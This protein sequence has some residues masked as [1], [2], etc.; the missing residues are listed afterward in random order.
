MEMALLR[1]SICFSWWMMMKLFF[2][3][4]MMETTTVEAAFSTIQPSRIT[5]VYRL[6]ADV[7]LGD[8]R[9]ASTPWFRERTLRLYL[10]AG[11]EEDQGD[12]NPPQGSSKNK[13]KKKPSNK[14]QSNADSQRKKDEL[15]KAVGAQFKERYNRQKPD[16]EQ[17]QQQQPE[18]ERD[19]SN[20]ILD[21][22]NPFKAGQT[23]RRTIDTAFSSMTAVGGSQQ[24]SKKSPY[25]LDDDDMMI[26]TTDGIDYVPE[27]LVVGATTDL[28]R[29]VVQQLLRSGQFRVRVLVRDLYT[30]TLNALGT[31]VT[32]CQGD[33]NDP[34]SLEYAVTDVDKLI[35]VADAPRPD[36]T[37]FRNKFHEFTRENL[38]TTSEQTTTTTTTTTHTKG[39][40]RNEPV[41]LPETPK[42]QSDW[43]WETLESVLEV[44]ARLAEQIDLVGMQNLIR[45]YQDV[46]HADYGTS[47]AAKR[48]LFKFQSR[49][50]DFY[51]FSLDEGD[52]MVGMAKNGNADESK[53]PDAGKTAFDS[54]NGRDEYDDVYDDYDEYEDDVYG[55]D[56]ET[57]YSRSMIEKRSDAVVKTQSQWIRNQFGHGVFVGRIPKTTSVISGEA[58]IISSRLRSREDP[59]NGIDLGP[60]FAGFVCRVCSDGGTY[61]AFVRTGVYERDGIEYV[62]EFS[63]F[64]KPEGR[65]KS[66]NKFT[67]VRLPFEN[68]KPV[69]RQD[70]RSGAYENVEQESIPP[71]RGKDVRNIGFRYRSASNQ[72]NSKMDKQGDEWNRFYL[73]LGYIKLYRAQPE[74]EFVYLS[75][76]RIPPV[77]RD[78]MVQHGARQISPLSSTML[79]SSS[80]RITERE[81]RIL[82]ESTMESVTGSKN[83]KSPEETYYKFLGEQLLKNSGLSYCIVRV[84]GFNESPSGE[85]STI[86]LRS[87]ISTIDEV[88]PVSRADVAKVCVSALLDPDALN[89]SFYVSK[90]KQGSA[91]NPDE[92]MHEKFAVLSIDKV[93]V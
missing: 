92:D 74:P 77:V 49:P 32:Y 59:D 69:R 22:I 78:G 83:G 34:D 42:T 53:K 29:L 66:K 86:D 50:G 62:C 65:N 17:S 47:Q 16:A 73:A 12:E 31:G 81:V 85:S 24:S 40:A 89:K 44:R 46:R 61:E 56:P 35:F 72:N 55:D 57:G 91:M 18:T 68:F 5:S 36:E 33:L 80:D 75:D 19:A 11:T 93:V 45:A 25:Y 41:P 9:I 20:R 3:S 63:T 48:A 70:S 38:R 7:L 60:A 51:L 30:S 10:A 84:L 90:K 28:G 79:Q 58:A 26:R 15:M 67:T 39:V 2:G 88:E 21:A 27:V 87:S 76:A 37:D 23:L 54:N 8:N 1:L 64:T 13:K 52:E 43:E 14:K 6:P 4:S 82:D 71:F